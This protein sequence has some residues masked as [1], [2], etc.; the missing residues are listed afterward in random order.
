MEDEQRI[1][2][3][4]S[5]KEETEHVAIHIFV[6][7]HAMKSLQTKFDEYYRVPK[8]CDKRSDF[9]VAFTPVNVRATPL[10]SGP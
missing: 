8:F 3:C 9:K 10:K 7:K 4:W 6:L 2:H 5:E 1:I